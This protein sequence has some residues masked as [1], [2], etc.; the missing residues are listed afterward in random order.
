MIESLQP[1]ALVVFNAYNDPYNFDYIKKRIQQLGI[2]NRC[3]ILISS[4]QFAQDCHELGFRFLP[5][6]WHWWWSYQSQQRVAGDAPEHCLPNWQNRQHRLS[7][8]NRLPNH[9]R[10]ITYYELQ[11]QPWFSQVHSSFGDVSGV[12]SFA[13][14]PDISQWFVQHR[15][16]F[17][18]SNEPNYDWG[19]SWET[20]VPAYCDSYAN[21]VTETF[22]Q[23]ILISEKTVK[24]LV[25]GNLIFVCANENFLSLLRILK[26]QIDFSGIN[27]NYD[28]ITGWRPRIQALT[29]EI[30]R[31][32][33][34]LPDIWHENLPALKYNRDWFL[35][36]DFKQLMLDDV[37]D[38][39]DHV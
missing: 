7:C 20:A 36:N 33:E 32:F 37:K 13:L 12:H 3:K 16:R 9:S 38:L 19:N 2:V 1:G 35:S 24:P 25:A 34:D 14:D 21:L 27:N 5:F 4:L 18:Y 29:K 6:A 10:F 31:V 22:S 17:P 30:D 23:H 8:L 26:F 11:S 28:K 39:F 15:D